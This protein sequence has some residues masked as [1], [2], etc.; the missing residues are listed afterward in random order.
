MT[1][2]SLEEKMKSFGFD[3]D[4]IN[5]H[6]IEEVYD[7]LMEKTDTSKVIIADTVKAN[8]ISFLVNN[9]ISHQTSLT[10][11]K[12]NQALEEIQTAYGKL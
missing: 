11:K 4:V 5:G 8:G 12:Y 6:S 7:T 3:L 1:Q 2:Y 10:Q 9:K